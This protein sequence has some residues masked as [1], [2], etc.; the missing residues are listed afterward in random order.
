MGH[1]TFW[2]SLSPSPKFGLRPKI[3]QK[4]KSFFVWT[5]RFHWAK[6]LRL[7]ATT[8]ITLWFY[9]LFL[10]LHQILYTY[11]V[12]LLS[13]ILE[14]VDRILCIMIF[15]ATFFNLTHF[16]STQI[17]T[18]YVCCN[19]QDVCSTTLLHLVKFCPWITNLW[20]QTELYHTMNM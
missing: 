19:L 15:W 7:F 8:D 20:P 1:F 16:P 2:I 9:L 6:S 4:V 13:G 17:V 10:S 3:S 14:K 5:Q 12:F 11:S 18:L